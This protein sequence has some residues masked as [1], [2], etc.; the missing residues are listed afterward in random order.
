R[1]LGFGCAWM[2]GTAGT[3]K[4]LV[5]SA[6]VENA[7]RKFAESPDAAGG[8]TCLRN[9]FA[10]QSDSNLRNTIN[11]VGLPILSPDGKS[12]MRGPYIRIPEI[13]GTTSVSLTSENVDKWAAKG[14]VDLR[15]QNFERWRQRFATMSARP[16]G[17]DERGSAAVKREGYPHEDIRVGA[18]VAWIFNNEILGYR[19]K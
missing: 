11:S 17:L 12:L 5:G 19:I 18:V 13:P 8:K 3:G 10:T 9:L 7:I 16:T 6:P 2:V 1:R 15:P 14:W 4:A